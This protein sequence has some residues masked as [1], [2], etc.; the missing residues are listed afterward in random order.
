[1]LN[2]L[3]IPGKTLEE[4]RN[5]LNV[6][7]G[8]FEVPIAVIGKKYDKYVKIIEKSDTIGNFYERGDKIYLYEN[9][10]CLKV[11]KESAP[12]YVDNS[13][14]Y[15]EW[16]D[17]PLNA[18]GIYSYFGMPIFWPDNSIFGTLSLYDRLPIKN[19]KEYEDILKLNKS[20]IEATLCYIFCVYRDNETSI[21]DLV[22][23]LKGKKIIKNEFEKEYE[24]FFCKRF[25]QRDFVQCLFEKMLSRTGEH[26]QHCYRLTELGNEFAK[27]LN[28]D[29][30]D[31]KNLLDTL[32]YHDIGN[33]LIPQKVI[34]NKAES[35]RAE[36]VKVHTQAGFLICKNSKRFSAI[37]VYVLHHHEKYDGS[38]YPLGLSGESI[39]Y[40]SRI[41]SIIDAFDCITHTNLS[42]KSNNDCTAAK[43]L[44]EINKMS[45]SFFD[46][47]LCEEF[48]K[49]MKEN[50]SL[51][52]VYCD[53]VFCWE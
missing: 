16:R 6:L 46:K 50:P 21:N 29:R 33:I 40:I 18:K 4:L 14:L 31:R 49:M 11:L 17:N 9:E 22:W 38:G 5:L 12:L 8:I 28:L 39:P 13:L 44:T 43:A 10:F 41:V 36:V 2:Q 53:D 52:N 3:P 32:R 34:M 7:T 15:E 35:E 30:R 48:I 20:I 47:K 37:A 27:R 45:G 24:K 51:Y 42:I 25:I 23:K 26:I 1:M 19:R